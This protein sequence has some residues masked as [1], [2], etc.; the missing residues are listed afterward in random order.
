M[1]LARKD[2]R[3]CSVVGQRKRARF[4]EP[5]PPPPEQ[6]KYGIRQAQGRKQDDRLM[7]NRGMSMARTDRWILGVSPDE[8]NNDVADHTL[9]FRLAASAPPTCSGGR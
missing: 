7:L 6:R 9:R 8:R 1:G 4:L 2:A 3:E 5:H